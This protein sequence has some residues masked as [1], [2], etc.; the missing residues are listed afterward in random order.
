MQIFLQYYLTSLDEQIRL[1]MEVIQRHYYVNIS[2]FG[3]ISYLTGVLDV[4]DSN[5]QILQSS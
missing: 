4:Y 1:I 3:D 5:L 2:G